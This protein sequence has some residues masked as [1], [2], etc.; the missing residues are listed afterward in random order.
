MVDFGKFSREIK[1]GFV[2]SAALF[3]GG[4]ATKQLHGIAIG[5][6][7]SSPYHWITGRMKKSV[8]GAAAD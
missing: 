2:R 8:A 1:N 6:L 4:K 5:D 7:S 3:H